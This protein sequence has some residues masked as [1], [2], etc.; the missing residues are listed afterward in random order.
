V[1]FTL[2]ANRLFLDKKFDLGAGIDYDVFERTED[3]FQ[4]ATTG[5]HI[6]TKF[7][8][9]GQYYFSKKVS[10]TLHVED[11]ISP[12]QDYNFAGWSTLQINF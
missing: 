11:T 1:G 7:W 8:L 10:L 5:Y 4:N 3:V 6:A 9:S 12:N 2:A